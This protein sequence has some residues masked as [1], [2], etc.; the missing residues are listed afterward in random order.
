MDP[1]LWFLKAMSN[2]QRPNVVLGLEDQRST[3]RAQAISLMGPEAVDE[4][5]ECPIVAW[6]NKK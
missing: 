2:E 4:I 3:F 6:S 1:L 5:W